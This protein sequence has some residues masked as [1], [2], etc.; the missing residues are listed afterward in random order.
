MRGKGLGDLL[1]AGKTGLDGGQLA[2]PDPLLAD[3]VADAQHLDDVPD[4][5]KVGGLHHLGLCPDLGQRSRVGD[6]KS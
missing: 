5:E 3:P 6:E 2:V 1:G 4:A